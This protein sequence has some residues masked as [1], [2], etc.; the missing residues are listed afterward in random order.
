MENAGRIYPHNWRVTEVV[1]QRK[2]VYDWL[3]SGFL[4]ASSVVWE[5][6]G[7]TALK[8]TH[9]NQDSFPQDDPAFHR[10]ACEG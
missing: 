10:Q 6:S 9:L 2:I 3:Y 4:G 5:L 1:P 7:H 8:L